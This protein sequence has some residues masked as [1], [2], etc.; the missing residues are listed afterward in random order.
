MPAYEFFIREEPPTKKNRKP[1]Y[2]F[3]EASTGIS[4]GSGYTPEEA[5]E[6]GFAFIF[7]STGKFS[8]G[9]EK[10]VHKYGITPRGRKQVCRILHIGTHNEQRQLGRVTPHHCSEQSVTMQ[11]EIEYSNERPTPKYERPQV[12]LDDTW[13]KATPKAF[14]DIRRADTKAKVEEKTKAESDL[15]KLFD[16]LDA[17]ADSKETVT[18]EGAEITTWHV[19]NEVPR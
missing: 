9:M 19:K 10:A 14:G 1:Y 8:T 5:Q 2:Y 12:P 18:E 3:C 13:H 17:V 11:V 16:V 7:S 15:T 6:N 4:L